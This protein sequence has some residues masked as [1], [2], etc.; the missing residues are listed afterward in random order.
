MTKAKNPS[1]G[2]E[3]AAGEDLLEG[4]VDGG[5]VALIDPV[6]PYRFAVLWFGIP[7]AL[8]IAGVYLRM[9]CGLGG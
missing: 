2:L 7:M 8:V 1:P 9:Q 5:R 4:E 6:S 3:H